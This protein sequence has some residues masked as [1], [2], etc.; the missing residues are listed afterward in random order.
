MKTKTWRSQS[1]L[2]RY[3]LD[4]H[5]PDGYCTEQLSQLLSAEAK[6]TLESVQ[7]NFKRGKRLE[8][9]AAKK[10]VTVNKPVTTKTRSKTKKE[11]EREKIPYRDILVTAVGKRAASF[12]EIEERKTHKGRQVNLLFKPVVLAVGHGKTADS[13]YAG[14]RTL[15]KKELVR[16]SQELQAAIE[17]M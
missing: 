17:K 5:G 7:E 1:F 6:P 9:Q 15:M 11:R 4:H 12:F 8:Q 16:V 2:P 10:P 13:A 3:G 14:A